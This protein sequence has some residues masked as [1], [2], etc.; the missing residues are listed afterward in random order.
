VGEP[1]WLSTCLGREVEG[2]LFLG[3]FLGDGRR[4]A[5]VGSQQRDGRAGEHDHGAAEE[6]MSVPVRCRLGERFVTG[7]QKRLGVRRR[8][9]CR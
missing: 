9:A 7:A 6:C 2:R 5:R 4:L 1:V 8:S 3:L